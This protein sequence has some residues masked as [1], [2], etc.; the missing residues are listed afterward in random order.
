METNNTKRRGDIANERLLPSISSKWVQKASTKLWEDED[1]WDKGESRPI[2]HLWNG[3]D[4]LPSK[5]PRFLSFQITQMPAR[6]EDCHVILP[7]TI[8]FIFIKFVALS[9]DLIWLGQVNSIWGWASQH[10]PWI[11]VLKPCFNLLFESHD[12]AMWITHVIGLFLSKHN[13]IQLLLGVLMGQ[14]IQAWLWP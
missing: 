10:T 6:K 3:I 4:D 5:H 12:I 14:A 11:W 2:S 7:L 1:P 9:R 13:Q 8:Y